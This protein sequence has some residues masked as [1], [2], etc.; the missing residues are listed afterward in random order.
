MKFLIGVQRWLDGL[1]PSQHDAL[2]TSLQ[3]LAV[4][5][6]GIFLGRCSA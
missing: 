3:V 2:I 6:L 5:W 1:S 4:L